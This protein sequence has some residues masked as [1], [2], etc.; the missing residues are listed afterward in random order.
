MAKL[1]DLGSASFV[2][3]AVTQTKGGK[4]A[5]YAA[6]ELHEGEEPSEVSD[7][8]AMGLTIFEALSG[9]PAFDPKLPMAKLLRAITGEERPKVPASAMPV[10]VEVIAGCWSSE[11]KS[12]PLVM[13][14][15]QKF[16]DVKWHLVQGADR[17]TVKELLGRFPLDETASREDLQ[18][19][20]EKSERKVSSQEEEI[21]NLKKRMSEMEGENTSLKKER[22]SLLE[23][24]E[25]LKKGK[26]VKVK[27]A[28]QAVVGQGVVMRTGEMTLKDGRKY[29]WRKRRASGRVVT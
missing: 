6:P 28:S 2:D 3:G 10:L 5:A 13:E 16:N 19:S 11:A 14:I 9:S 25:R 20:L 26:T 18:A 7:V 17:K 21:A 24:M 23:E 8:W 22:G 27:D 15:C 12:R 4:T 29:G 1:S